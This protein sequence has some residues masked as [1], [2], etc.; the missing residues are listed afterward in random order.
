MKIPE[1]RLKAAVSAVETSSG[2]KLPFRCR[3]IKIDQTLIATAMEILNS[4]PNKTLPQHSANAVA[5][6]TRDGFD[7]RLKERLGNLRR[8]NIISD[9]LAKAEIV[10]V[11]TV[12]SQQT[13]RNVK[14]T[15]LL[16][17]W[18]W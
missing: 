4:Q 12:L 17:E 2:Q 7:R 16:L 18:T 11:K 3:G 13:G 15:T 6:K 1:E 14:G 8:A 5:E 9:V 10:V